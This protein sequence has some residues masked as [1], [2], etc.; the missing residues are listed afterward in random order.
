M[1]N[2][3]AY[4]KPRLFNNYTVIAIIVIIFSSIFFKELN[5][6]LT[7]IATTPGI[8]QSIVAAIISW[9]TAY[10]IHKK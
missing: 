8:V 2:M 1:K 3:I 5:M 6:F 10:L 4:W 7:T 9:V